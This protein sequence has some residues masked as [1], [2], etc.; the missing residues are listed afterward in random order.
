MVVQRGKFD[1]TNQKHY[2]N[3]S[4]D[5]SSEWNFC[6][7]FSGVIWRGNKWQ[8]GQMSAV[9]SGYNDYELIE[10][11]LISSFSFVFR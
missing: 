7:R 4:S 6:A 9:F 5:A 1:S 8:R 2:P 10:F 3:L 11:H